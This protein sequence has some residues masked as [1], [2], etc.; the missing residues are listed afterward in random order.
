M[1]NNFSFAEQLDISHGC[2]DAITAILKEQIPGVVAVHPARKC[3]DRRGT[4]FWC[5]MMSGNHLSV[6][7]KIRTADWSAKAEPER[8]DDLALEIWSVMEKKIPGWTRDE[9]KRTDYVLWYWTD[10]QRWCLVPFAMLCQVFRTRWQ[11]WS[12][13]FRTATQRTGNYHSQCVFVPRDTVWA[14]I[15]HHCNSKIKRLE[16]EYER[17]ATGI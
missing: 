3:N 5:E 10:T 11:S 9:S 4:D 16:G 7:V 14:E 1:P 12:V 13:E 8:E 17:E 2:H 6:D 15:Y